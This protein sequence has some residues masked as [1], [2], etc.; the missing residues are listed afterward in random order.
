MAS[1]ED[2]D[3]FGNY[4]GADVDSDDEEDVQQETYG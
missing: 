3:E 1:L 2:N 4:I